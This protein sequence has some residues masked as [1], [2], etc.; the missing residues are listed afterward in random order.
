MAVL[1]SLAMGGAGS[2]GADTVREKADDKAALERAGFT[3]TVEP[4]TRPLLVRYGAVAAARIR[5]SFVWRVRAGEESTED[6]LDA[7]YAIRTEAREERL[8]LAIRLLETVSNG[9]RRAPGPD[10]VRLEGEASRQGELRNIRIEFPAREAAALPVPQPGSAAYASAIRKATRWYPRFAANPIVSGDVLYRFPLEQ[11]LGVSPGLKF[12]RGSDVTARLAGKAVI[13]ERDGLVTVISGVGEARGDDLAISLTVSG[14]NIIDLRTGL[15]L[16]T[17]V[18]AFGRTRY[19]DA[20]ANVEGNLT[21]D[22][23]FPD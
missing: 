21:R 20:E 15:P 1:V 4:I 13:G 11:V 16:R 12:E 7:L 23:E 5:T 19:G 8:G 6:R 17:R 2:T 10:L 22:T 14:Y 9:I 18:R 3:G